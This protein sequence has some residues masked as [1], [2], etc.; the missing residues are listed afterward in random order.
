MLITQQQKFKLQPF[1]H[2]FVFYKLEQ[3]IQDHQLH[4]HSLQEHRQLHGVLLHLLAFLNF[5]QPAG[6]LEEILPTL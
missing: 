3:I 5:L 1:I 6:L 4:F 2:G